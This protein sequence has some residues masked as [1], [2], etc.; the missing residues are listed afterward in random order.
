MSLTLDLGESGGNAA[1]YEHSA[2]VRVQDP[3][4]ERFGPDYDNDLITVVCECGQV[5]EEE[6]PRGT[7]DEETI[8]GDDTPYL[9]RWERHVYD[10]VHRRSQVSQPR[11]QGGLIE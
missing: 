6:W 9:D 7:Y 11:H 8:T 5:F 2:E 3:D 10:E 1:A 4:P